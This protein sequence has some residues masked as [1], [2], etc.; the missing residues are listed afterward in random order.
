[1]RGCR[2]DHIHRVLTVIKPWQI[3]GCVQSTPNEIFLLCNSVLAGDRELGHAKPL[4]YLWWTLLCSCKSVSNIRRHLS[5]K[6]DYFV[7]WC[8]RYMAFFTLVIWDTSCCYRRH[9]SML[10]R[11]LRS[12]TVIIL[13]ITKLGSASWRSKH[14]L[15][16]HSSFPMMGVPFCRHSH[17]AMMVDQ[18]ATWDPEEGVGKELEGK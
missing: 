9:F 6:T 3:Y 2:T 5:G 11:L 1:M 14:F 10:K 17:S 8:L 13:N 12:K 7:I 16:H 15:S 18:A 4:H